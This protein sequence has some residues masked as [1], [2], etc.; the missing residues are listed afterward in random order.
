MISSILK[1]KKQILLTIV[2]ISAMIPVGITSYEIITTDKNSVRFFEGYPTAISITI[3]S[4]YLLLILIGLIW[5]VRYLIS[6]FRLRNEIV[7]NELRHLQNQVNPHFFFNI[8]NSLYGLV[9]KDTDKA[10]QLIIK[11]SDMMRYSIYD[12]Q[13]DTVTIAQEIDYLKN[14]V[15]LHQMR[16]H[17][18]VNTAFDITVENDQLKIMPLMFIILVENAFKHGVE[19]LR[20]DAFIT[21]KLH[22]TQNSLSFEVENNFDKEEVSSQNGLGLSNLKRRLDLVYPKKHSLSS[23]STKNI[24][25]AHLTLQLL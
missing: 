21:I 4:Y 19:H 11:L 2:L 23:S 18:A 6:F 25:K 3:F 7:K 9:D 16:Y 12:G 15:A 20:K 14:Y 22:A 17:K 24:Y 8:L 1:N 10:K 5:L 13:Q